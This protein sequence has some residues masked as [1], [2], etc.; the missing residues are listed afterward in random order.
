V[1][2]YSSEYSLKASKIWLANGRFMKVVAIIVMVGSQDVCITYYINVVIHMSCH[3]HLLMRLC[4]NIWGLNE[5]NESLNR[6]YGHR[7]L[8]KLLMQRYSKSSFILLAPCARGFFEHPGGYLT[9][10]AFRQAAIR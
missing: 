7:L 1:N 6:K 8:Q 2:S 5:K 3:H 10:L 4:P 9:L